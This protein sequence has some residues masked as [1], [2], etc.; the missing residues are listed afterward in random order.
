MK[1]IEHNWI[2]YFLREVQQTKKLSIISP[3]ISKGI[4]EKLLDRIDVSNLSLITRFS[5]QDFKLGVS[6]LKA[7]KLLVENGGEVRGIKK[8]HSKV[9][10]FDKRLGIT[11]SANLTHGGLYYNY[12]LGAAFTE[13][14]LINKTH[15]YFMFLWNIGKENLTIERIRQ[16]EKQLD[17]V[18][19]STKDSSSLV[20]YG[21]STDEHLT[22]ENCFVKFYGRGNDRS[23]LSTRIK[24]F[25]KGTE[26]HYAVTF[27]PGSLNRRPRKFN[28]GDIVYIT[29]MVEP[30]DYRI[31]GKAIALKHNDRRDV[32]SNEEKGR[33]RWKNKYSVYIRIREPEF[34]DGTLG[35]GISMIELI[36][37]FSYMAMPQTYLRH[38]YGDTDFNIW[39]YFRRKA[40]INLSPLV[41]EWVESELKMRYRKVGK[42]TQT[43]INRLPQSTVPI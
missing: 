6:D 19:L 5:L 26:C 9:Y 4:V 33:V 8:L 15:S 10:L 12:E 39:N 27:N 23:P 13:K 40:Y 25:I 28:D 37:R 16:W 7:V 30:D 22:G 42:I 14:P 2:D 17:K 24:D 35:N 38:E 18:V 31:L 21:A 32:A 36:K 29:A 1:I 3:F 41:A 11:T 34:I 20:D 43:F